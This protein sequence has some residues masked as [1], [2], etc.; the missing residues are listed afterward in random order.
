MAGYSPS[1]QAFAVDKLEPL[2]DGLKSAQEAEKVA[3]DSL[4]AHRDATRAAERAFHEA[5]LGAKNQVIAQFGED[6]DEVASLGLKK[7][8]EYK[9]GGKRSKADTMKPAA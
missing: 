8:S 1:N 7:K 2:A 6:S 4:S 3:A 5:I 9:K